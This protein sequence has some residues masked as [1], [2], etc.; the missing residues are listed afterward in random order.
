MTR[1][2]VETA[3]KGSW[4]VAT[5][6]SF[7]LFVFLVVLYWPAVDFRMLAFDDEHY[8]RDNN[9]IAGGLD[10]ANIVK[11]FTT[12][13]EEDQFI[14]VTRLSFMADVAF[15]G[16]HSSRGFHLT[17]ILIFAIDM[18]LLL[19]L[20][21]RL[22]GE[23]ARS[24]LATALVALHPLR[25]ESVAWV[26][27]RKDVLAVFFLILSIGC[28]VRFARKRQ[29]AWYLPALLSCAFSML[30]KPLAVTLP[31]LLLALDYWPLARFGGGGNGREDLSL[32]KRA[33]PLLAE[34]IPFFVLS[35]VLTA[36]TYHLQGKG[37][38]HGDVSIVSRVEHA[39]S[40]VFIYL[41]QTFWP[42]GLIY[43]FFD[44]PWNRFSGSLIPAI[45]GFAIVTGVV[46]RFSGKRPWLA[47]GWFW[48]LVA[49]LPFS[50]I[51]PTG[52]QWISNRFTFLPHFGLMAALVWLAAES[53]PERHR[54]MLILGMALLLLPVLAF[55]TREQLS[56]WKDGVAMFGKGLSYSRNDPRYV[57]QYAVELMT[58]GDL[59]GAWKQIESIRRHA[60]NTDYGMNFQ[61]TAME[62]L[63]RK[64]DRKG[65][66]EL[67]RG[68]L[69]ED[70]RFWET[71]LKMADYLL[72]EEKFKE[73]A[74]EYRQV[75]E[76]RGVKSFHLGYALEGMG[77]S[78]QGMGKGDEALSAFMAGLRENPMSP[79]LHY[80][81][82]LHFA[83]AGEPDPARAHFIEAIRIDPENLRIRLALADH[84]FDSGEQA[85]GAEMFLQVAQAAPG[86]AESFYAFGRLAGAQGDVVQSKAA[87][88]EALRAPAVWNETRELARK[89]LG[90]KSAR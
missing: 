9:L 8:T 31:V 57:G 21:W 20:L 34:K 15:Y 46:I 71:R 37:A 30:S 62:I 39:F 47:F 58:L 19:I 36:V 44:T 90:G 45:L 81:L 67:A 88:Q 52:I 12:L 50:G 75:I 74:A 42:Q 5:L 66:I 17:N 64:G 4:C 29:W 55:L 25:V 38:L 60:L 63:D 84:L 13:P 23:L 76:N 85:G 77:L 79:T 40:S 68:Y 70:Y 69:R 80:H 86:K 1:P 27:E 73:A 11:I 28:Y 72:A 10:K 22:T 87:Y 32:A 2:A 56:M 18:A 65:A 14:P 6:A 33:L 35:L 49:I 78:L 51:I 61:M 53:V 43:S 3:S 26:T 24:A 48:F 89:R 7:T 83:R 54:R 16:G 82:A 59:D 41:F